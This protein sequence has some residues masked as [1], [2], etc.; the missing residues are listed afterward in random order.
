M[1]KAFEGAGSLAAGAAGAGLLAAGAAG[2]A[3]SLQVPALQVVV[4]AGLAFG[5]GV[6]LLKVCKKVQDFAGVVSKGVEALEALKDTAQQG[7]QAL[8]ALKD[9][10]QGMQVQMQALKFEVRGLQ[11]HSQESV[12]KVLEKMDL[13]YDRMD[14]CGN[15]LE[16]M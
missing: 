16:V 13:Q 8:E 9:T 4:V 2:A 1:A 10:A 7:M 12:L 15:K 5:G 3:G 11:V 6:L 14:K